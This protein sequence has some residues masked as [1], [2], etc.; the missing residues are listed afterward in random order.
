MTTTLPFGLSGSLRVAKKR[1]STPPTVVRN[2]QNLD[3]IVD[4]NL[5]DDQ[6]YASIFSK[7]IGHKLSNGSRD[8]LYFCYRMNFKSDVVQTE[9]PQFVDLEIPAINTLH[10]SGVLGTPATSI[11]RPMYVSHW[12]MPYHLFGD[13]T[14]VGMSAAKSDHDYSYKTDFEIWREIRNL[15]AK[16]FRRVDHLWARLLLAQ[17]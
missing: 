11:R 9:A 16:T 17:T 8:D 7:V 15:S 4:G 12:S 3:V 6:D 1:Q 10:E 13:A 5:P 2:S 14:S